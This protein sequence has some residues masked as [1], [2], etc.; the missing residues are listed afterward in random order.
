MMLS[1]SSQLLG[2][3]AELCNIIYEQIL[4]SAQC[5]KEFLPFT[6]T[7]RTIHAETLTLANESPFGFPT[8]DFVLEP[9]NAS[10]ARENWY[11]EPLS[12][13]LA[14][15]QHLECKPFWSNIRERKQHIPADFSDFASFK[16]VH[17]IIAEEWEASMLE[18]R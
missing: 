5:L 4:Q 13:D 17:V 15:A 16:E 10:K 2:L 11:D 12:S 1:S 9:N 6:Q 14:I 18:N 3:P 8:Q 7:C